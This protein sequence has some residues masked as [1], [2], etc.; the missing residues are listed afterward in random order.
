MIHS[1]I[2]GHYAGMVLCVFGIFLIG[3]SINLSI[4]FANAMLSTLSPW[5]LLNVACVGWLVWLFYRDLADT[6]FGMGYWAGK[7]EEIEAALFESARASRD[8]F[9]PERRIEIWRV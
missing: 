2:D 6:L 7:Q 8:E 5:H 1:K 4:L 9:P 3:V